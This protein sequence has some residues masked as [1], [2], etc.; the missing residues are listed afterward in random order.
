MGRAAGRPAGPA[1]CFGRS[2]PT[3]PWSTLGEVTQELTQALLVVA[4][5]VLIDGPFDHD[6]AAE[7]L[8]AGTERGGAQTTERCSSTKRARTAHRD[9]KYASRRGN[10]DLLRGSP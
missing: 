7:R 4:D 10:L 9:G 8:E 3:P 1:G 2:A 5:Q 6:G